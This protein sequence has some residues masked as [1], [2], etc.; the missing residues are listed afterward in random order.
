MMQGEAVELSA[1]AGLKDG[2]CLID[3]PVR[4]RERVQLG[5]NEEC[6]YPAAGWL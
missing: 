1:V 4:K 6:L 2:F 5:S 3:M